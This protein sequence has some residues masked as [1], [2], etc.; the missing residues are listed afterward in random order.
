MGEREIVP[1][2]VLKLLL[3]EGRL[4]VCTGRTSVKKISIT[5]G[6]KTEVLLLYQSPQAF[7]S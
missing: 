5:F 7:Y 2:L 3:K 4:V 1:E 6:E